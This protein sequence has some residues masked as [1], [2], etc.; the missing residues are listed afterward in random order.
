MT[1]S[2]LPEFG[3]PLWTSIKRACLLGE[4]ILQAVAHQLAQFY[5]RWIR[6]GIEDLEPLFAARQ[7]AGGGK[8]LKVPRDVSLGAPDLFNEC[9]HVLL[10]LEEGM[11]QAQPHGLGKDG[12]P[13]GDQFD[14][15]Y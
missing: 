5:N 13:T 15:F 7:N 8:C 11:D 10:S 2:A 14:G 12:K 9:V 1:V 4:L 3:L 6:N